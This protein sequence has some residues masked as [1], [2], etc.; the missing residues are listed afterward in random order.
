MSFAYRHGHALSE[1]SNGRQ[2]ALEALEALEASPT[3]NLLNPR[4]TFDDS[5]AIL[6]ARPTARPLSMWSYSSSPAMTPS[7][8][9]TAGAGLHAGSSRQFTHN[10]LHSVSG[11]SQS[12]KRSSHW[13][14]IILPPAFLPHSPPPAHVSGFA[15]GYGASGRYSGGILIP[16]QPTL[17]LQLAAVARDFSLPSTGGL[18]LHLNLNDQAY[19]AG[20]PRITEDTWPVLFGW[21]F[22]EPPV[23]LPGHTHPPNGLLSSIGLPVAARLEFDID[24]RKARWY[25]AWA[26]SSHPTSNILPNL[27]GTPPK[28][29]SKTLQTLHLSNHIKATSEVVSPLASSVS[30]SGPRSTASSGVGSRRAGSRLVE[31][32]WKTGEESQSRL[33]EHKTSDLGLL[34]RSCPS[35]LLEEDKGEL[36]E[37]ETDVSDLES[38]QDLENQVMRSSQAPDGHG[39]IGKHAE[40]NRDSQSDSSRSEATPT[41]L[42]FS[43]RDLAQLK[44]IS[45]QQPSTDQHMIVTQQEP[46]KATDAADKDQIQWEEATDVRLLIDKKQQAHIQAQNVDAGRVKLGQAQECIKTD[47]MKAIEL[48]EQGRIEA[49]KLTQARLLAEKDAAKAE[50]K[51]MAVMEAAE[52]ER[53][54][55]EKVTQARVLAERERAEAEAEA[56][57]I[58]AMELAEQERIAAEKRIQENSD[59]ERKKDFAVAE[60]A[61]IKRADSD[62]DS[63]SNR[64]TSH[65]TSSISSAASSIR[66]FSGDLFARRQ[67]QAE[68]DEE[69][70]QKIANEM[71]RLVQEK[72]QR[73]SVALVSTPPLPPS[74]RTLATV[75]VKEGPRD[76]LPPPTRS[77]VMMLAKA[78]GDEASRAVSPTWISNKPRSRSS[79]SSVHTFDPS[80]QNSLLQVAS[81]PAL[82]EQVLSVPT[83]VD[84]LAHLLYSYSDH[85]QLSDDLADFIV[86]AQDDALARHQKFVIALSGGSLPKLLA[87]GLLNKEGVKWDAWRVFFADERI[88]P[89]DH[90]DSNFFACMEALFS[91][92]PIERS[93]IITIMGLPPDG[94]DLDEIS[95]DIASIYEAQILDEINL[96]P[97]YPRFDMILLGM[98]DDGHTCSLFPDHR[99]L[100]SQAIVT[101]LNDSPK[102]P[103][104]RISLTLPVLNLA[105]SLA[106]VCTGAGKQKMLADVFEQGSSRLRPSSLIKLPERPIS[107]FVDA[108]AAGGTK[109]TR[110]SYQ[111]RSVPVA[112]TVDTSV[113]THAVPA[114]SS[115][116]PSTSKVVCV[117]L[118][119]YPFNLVVYPAVYPNFD[120]MLYPGP[121]PCMMDRNFFARIPLQFDI[122]LKSSASNF[123]LTSLDSEAQNHAEFQATVTRTNQV[124][125]IKSVNDR[126]RS[127]DRG[128][129]VDLPALARPCIDTEAVRIQS[130]PYNL[131]IYRSVYPHV[132]GT[133]YLPMLPD[134]TSRP[135]LMKVML[136]QFSED[137]VSR[138][139][140]NTGPAELDPSHSVRIKLYP[141]VRGIIYPSIEELEE[142]SKSS[143][144]GLATLVLTSHPPLPFSQSQRELVGKT[145]EK[146]SA[147][148]I[149]RSLASDQTISGVSNESSSPYSASVKVIS[150]RPSSPYPYNMQ[151]YQAV[152]PH[153]VHSIYPSLSPQILDSA[154]SVDNGTVTSCRSLSSQAPR[155]YGILDPSFSV[156]IETYP[157]HRGIVYPSIVDQYIVSSCSLPSQPKQHTYHPDSDEKDL[158]N[159]TSEEP[160]PALK[161]A[162]QCFQILGLYPFDLQIYPNIYPHIAGS[163]YPCLPPQIIEHTSTTILQP[164]LPGFQD[165]GPRLCDETRSTSSELDTLTSVRIGIYSFNSGI[166]PSMTN[167]RDRT[168]ASFSSTNSSS[169]SQTQLTDRASTESL[170]V[171]VSDKS[172]PTSRKVTTT[173]MIPCYPFNMHIY[174]VA[175]PNLAH[176]IY[177]NILPQIII[178]LSS[179]SNGSGEFSSSS[180]SQD[181]STVSGP[182]PSPEIKSSNLRSLI[183]RPNYPYSLSCF[184][185]SVYPSLESRLYPSLTP[186]LTALLRLNTTSSTDISDAAPA[187]SVS[188]DSP[189]LSSTT[190][191]NEHSFAGGFD[192]ELKYPVNLYQVYPPVYPTIL[193]YPSIIGFPVK[194][195][196]G[197]S[198]SQSSSTVKARQEK[199]NH[200]AMRSVSK[201]FHVV[202]ASSKNVVAPS[203]N[204]C[205]MDSKLSDD[206]F[207]NS[208]RGS[209]TIHGIQ[210]PVAIQQPTLSD[211]FHS[212]PSTPATLPISIEPSVPYNQR[213]SSQE[214][215]IGLRTQ[216]STLDLSFYGSGAPPIPPFDAIST[217]QSKSSGSPVSVQQSNLPDVYHQTAPD[218]LS[219]QLARSPRSPGI[220]ALGLSFKSEPAQIPLVGFGRQGP[221]LDPAFYGGAGGAANSQVDRGLTTVSSSL[222]RKYP[223]PSQLSYPNTRLQGDARDKEAAEC[224]SPLLPERTPSADLMD[225]IGTETPMAMTGSLSSCQA[226][227]QER[228]HINLVEHDETIQVVSLAQASVVTPSIAIFHAQAGS[229]VPI[230]N[231]TA[232]PPQENSSRWGSLQETDSVEMENEPTS[233]DRLSSSDL[234][235]K[236]IITPPSTGAIQAQSSVS[237]VP[238]LSDSPAKTMIFADREIEQVPLAQI[239]QVTPSIAEFHRKD[240]ESGAAK[241]EEPR[242]RTLKEMESIEMSV[243]PA[244]PDRL[245]SADFTSR[246]MMSRSGSPEIQFVDYSSGINH[247]VQASQEQYLIES[248]KKIGI[249]S[250][251]EASEI[252]P[253]ISKFHVSRE[254]VCTKEVVAD[255]STNTHGE[256]SSA[257]K[258]VNI[259]RPSSEANS[260]LSALEQLQATSPSPRGELV[261]DGQSPAGSVAEAVVEIVPKFDRAIEGEANRS[262]DKLSSTNE[263]DK[264]IQAEA[265]SPSHLRPG[266]LPR[267]DESSSASSSTAGRSPIHALSTDQW[268]PMATTRR[269][270]ITDD[271]HRASLNNRMSLRVSPPMSLDLSPLLRSLEANATRESDASG[272][273]EDPD[274]FLAANMEED[275]PEDPENPHAFDL[276]RLKE[277]TGRTPSTT[278]GSGIDDNVGHDWV[279]GASASL[280]KEFDTLRKSQEAQMTFSSS[281]IPLD[282]HDE[283]ESKLILVD[284]G[285]VPLVGGPSSNGQTDVN[286]PPLPILFQFADQEE[287]SEG[288]AQF[289]YEA[290]EAAL[291]RQNCFRI[292]LS[293]GLLPKVLAAGILHDDQI[294]W[295][296]W[297]VLIFMRRSRRPATLVPA[298]LRTFWLEH[299][300]LFFV[301]E[302]LVSPHS[303]ESTYN[304]YQQALLNHVP[305]TAEHVHTITRLTD[306]ELQEIKTMDNGLDTATDGLADDY[307]REMLTLFPGASHENGLAPKFDLILL[308]L[309]ANG[310]V[311][312]L[313]PNHPL[314][315]E[316]NWYVAWLGDAPQ[317]P[318]HRVTFTLPL[319]NAAHQLALVAMGKDRAGALA[320]ALRRSVESDV[321]MEEDRGNPAALL[322]TD[323]RPIVWFV[324]NAAAQDTDY[325]KSHF[326]DE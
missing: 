290:Q 241:E 80:A 245:P 207:C 262:S 281:P 126:Y 114:T 107:W 286:P 91:K 234:I 61:A 255:P 157:F 46:L 311:G 54:E 139:F 36:E 153:I 145:S 148:Q 73:A 26:N 171:G 260:I 236:L 173:L 27:R 68:K 303:P 32:G 170:V 147:D 264:S 297:S 244:S 130:Y 113:P 316:S 193:P 155:N 42:D 108:A 76:P 221:T 64:H 292:A 199:L 299:R 13:A 248:D 178:P 16:L 302:A 44:G 271:N 213:P 123:A 315:G 45:D 7:S 62:T 202:L 100:E 8:S 261:G 266:S 265:H 253:S 14:V 305:I 216:S 19:G 79:L 65:Q 88:V 188:K 201:H 322:R 31:D 274:T 158:E 321:P 3:P 71:N 230:D 154:V 217:A 122:N 242:L 263:V 150:T 276:S 120:T 60:A 324:D 22:D 84:P 174:R 211:S 307:E 256:H 103:P 184:Y 37:A 279:S 35:K 187:Q 10:T 50:A 240:P 218:L 273:V 194:H 284:E 308:S 9:T 55:A 168:I 92:V 167:G 57:I 176:S 206:E 251:Y 181:S 177:P 1:S 165:C 285:E 58:A 66:R 306:S 115:T 4:N 48:A 225:R 75:P 229:V 195:E 183:C 51:I 215:L 287:I 169:Q 117:R 237:N 278:C 277:I 24:L 294:E 121:V 127:S 18:T 149:S 254:E 196:V 312:C 2:Q 180:G 282:S 23:T 269:H 112:Q 144:A 160:S 97:N 125:S 317:A 119:R 246:M 239:S 185:P 161:K 39:G 70:A 40:L 134:M 182:G 205:L 191:L 6:P 41:T 30:P 146:V 20:A 190:F 99:L 81:V 106:F 137:P 198:V 280:G 162:N 138:S 325:P 86:R 209:V 208:T 268:S 109:H 56:K 74:P 111:S 98:G 143:S 275:S 235:E 293:G 233:P 301:D 105:H 166:Y 320:D 232:S 231:R 227:Y 53:I 295:T 90:P 323:P 38:I 152:Y 192:V 288:L 124:D 163:I 319:L 110:T 136:D 270:L 220:S 25:E 94:M 49:E 298:I 89:L 101:W 47:G 67:S 212:I 272:A 326:W 141:F 43:S 72:A 164:S 140:V 250:L 133:L 83:V 78:F 15:H 116:S 132:Q 142:Q 93:Q 204:H 318:T 63:T 21:A 151:I 82:A 249:V 77:K 11:P 203:I 129:V 258:N 304:Q 135:K 159:V 214:A 309:G 156:R 238:T 223:S 219:P 12:Q 200:T 29:E 267:S 243:E 104:H 131:Q 296:K 252:S 289:V 314:L 59:L 102:T 69:E 87:S 310:D 52:K 313:F 5:S 291:Q 224:F 17:T 226:V 222:P 247:E 95:G 172:L 175:Y 197:G 283:E 300:E 257:K 34:D 179:I 96:E 118:D 128:L 189:P 28:R 259:S 186:V 85:S 33:E 210:S 228:E